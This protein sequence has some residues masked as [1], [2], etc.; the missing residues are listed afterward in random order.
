M[1]CM[2]DVVLQ[3]ECMFLT[4]QVA[5]DGRYGF[6]EMFLDEGLGEACTGEKVT[7]FDGSEDGWYQRAEIF[8]M[9]EG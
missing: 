9:E 3:I 5:F 8:T 2:R 7:S 4:E 1:E 6:E